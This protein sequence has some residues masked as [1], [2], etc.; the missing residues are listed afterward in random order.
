MSDWSGVSVWEDEKG[1]GT[2]GWDDRAE[3][4]MYF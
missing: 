2:G 3:M 4:Y 1:S